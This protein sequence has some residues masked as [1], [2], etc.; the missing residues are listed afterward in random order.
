[1]AL[2]ENVNYISDI[3]T[4]SIKILVLLHFLFAITPLFAQ[5]DG[6]TEEAPIQKGFQIGLY[7]G[8]LL[9]NNYT[10]SLHDGYGLDFDGN[11]NS[12]ENS[13]M[14]QK[15]IME[16]GGGYP[17]SPDLIA[18]ELNVVHGEWNFDESDMPAYMRYQPSFL[19]GLQGRYSIDGKNVILLNVNV[20]QLTSNGSF[21]ITTIPQY[22]PGQ[23]AK[24]I[25]DFRIKGMEQRLMFQL[26][27]QH[28]FGKSERFNFLLEGGVNITLSKLGK[29]VIQINNLTI[30]LVSPYYY[31]GYPAYQVVRRVGAGFGAFTGIGFN[32]NASEKAIIQLIYNPSY[33]GINIGAETRLKWQHAIGLRAYY[34]L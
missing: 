24:T 34:K 3:M 6:E 20:A 23:N 2:P 10:A 15:I 30:D 28:L 29:N 16:Y 4:K 13:Y 32:F 27:Y 22:V 1:M 11:R 14:Y 7:V 8:S 26:G 33:E 5:E 9:A 31:V 18:T 25:H 12:F 19:L 17:G 21:T